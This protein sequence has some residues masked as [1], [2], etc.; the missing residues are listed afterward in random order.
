MAK[1]HL[2]GRMPGDE[3][4]RFANLRAYYGF[5]F[6]HPGK[7]LLFMGSEIAP[8]TEWNHNQSLDWHL[9]QYPVHQGVQNVVRDLNRLYRSIPALHVADCEH[10]GFEWLESDAADTSVIA[11]MRRG[12]TEDEVVVVV[13]NFTPVVRYDYRVGVPMQ[14][15]YEEK[16]NTDSTYYGGSNVGNDGGRWSDDQGHHSRP[17]SLRLTLPPLATIVLT[18]NKSAQ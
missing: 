7:K 16:L 3:W 15:F 17:Y 6:T 8:Y 11:Y 5:M 10:Q 1:V 12:K 14:G 18:Y 2:L 9:L 13:C 4:Q